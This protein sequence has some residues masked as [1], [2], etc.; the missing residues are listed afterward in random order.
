MTNSELFGLW[1]YRTFICAII[2]A[3]GGA[4]I[5]SIA[6]PTQSNSNELIICGLIMGGLFLAIIPG[7]ITVWYL[8]LSMISQT[9]SAVRGDGKSIKT[10]YNKEDKELNILIQNLEK[11]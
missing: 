4:I 8:F 1:F 2:G 7:I 3:V 11:K 10:S 5:S 9:A 6:M